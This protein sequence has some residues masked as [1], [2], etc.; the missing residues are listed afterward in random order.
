[1]S[2]RAMDLVCALDMK[3]PQAKYV[4]LMIAK[5]SDDKLESY[6]SVERLAVLTGLS[7]RTVQRKVGKLRDEGY[8]FISRRNMNQKQTSNLYKLTINDKPRHSV[9]STRQSV[10]TTPTDC[11]PNISLDISTNISLDENEKVDWNAIGLE[12]MG[13]KSK[14]KGIENAKPRK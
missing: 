4:L 14:T 7:S 8:V 5:H 12:A 11:H 3:D 2:Y 13:A 9:A 10:V 1:M 6:P